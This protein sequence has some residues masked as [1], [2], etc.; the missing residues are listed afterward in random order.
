MEFT[1]EEERD[2]RLPFMDTTVVRQGSKLQTEVYRKPTHTGRHLSFESHHPPQS[3][4]SVVRALKERKQ[5]V[6]AD[7]DAVRAEEAKVRNELAVNEYSVE[8]VNEAMK[9]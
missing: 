3:K 1:T 4:R 5:Y 7:E 6:T 2:G 8:F 9:D